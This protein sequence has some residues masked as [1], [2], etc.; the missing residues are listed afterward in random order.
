MGLKILIE[1]ISQFKER[2]SLGFVLSGQVS[3][4]RLNKKID[5]SF[6]FVYQ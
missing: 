4:S 3:S 2:T 1:E 5:G 6:I